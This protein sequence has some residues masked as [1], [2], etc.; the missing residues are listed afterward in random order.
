[1]FLVLSPILFS[2]APALSI[3]ILDGYLQLPKVPCGLGFELS[4][5]IRLKYITSQTVEIQWFW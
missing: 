1:M 2:V 3:G 5:E 4:I